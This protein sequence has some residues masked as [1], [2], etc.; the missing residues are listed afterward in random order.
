MQRQTDDE[1]G[2]KRTRRRQRDSTFIV[3]SL[4]QSAIDFQGSWKDSGPH[5]SN[6]Q[7]LPAALPN[8][9]F[10]SSISGGAVNKPGRSLCSFPTET[11]DEWSSITMKITSALRDNI[12]GPRLSAHI[13][14]RQ[15]FL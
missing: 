1:E 13:S 11:E 9:I 5:S 14:P 2:R 6:Y 8:S 10:I 15:D 12:Y 4:K 7:T 3:L